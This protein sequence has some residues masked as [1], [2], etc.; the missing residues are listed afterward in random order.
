[1]HLLLCITYHENLCILFWNKI[2]GEKNKFAL[3]IKVK[4][5]GKIQ[6]I[7]R[8]RHENVRKKYVMNFEYINNCD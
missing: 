1:M 8:K 3:I 2:K 5:E 4:T 6:I 7:E